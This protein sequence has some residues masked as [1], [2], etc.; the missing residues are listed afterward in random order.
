M[1]SKYPPFERK[2]ANHLVANESTILVRNRQ[3][4]MLLRA[5][6]VPRPGVIYDRADCV[7]PGLYL[8]TGIRSA[9]TS[10]GWRYSRYYQLDLVDVTA[11]PF[12]D[13]YTPRRYTT[14]PAGSPTRYNIIKKG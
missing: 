11:G 7:P 3:D 8:V 4:D 14:A 12:T 10:S 6:A 9:L 1:A 2:C 13:S 5:D